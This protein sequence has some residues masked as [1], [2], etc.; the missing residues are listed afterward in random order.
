MWLAGGVREGGGELGRLG[1]IGLLLLID[2]DRQVGKVVRNPR[3]VLVS[4]QGA[5]R[6]VMVYR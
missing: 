4:K 5:D 6:E 2:Y 3:L 1:Q